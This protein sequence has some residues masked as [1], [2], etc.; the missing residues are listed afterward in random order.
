MSFA[1]EPMAKGWVLAG[2][3]GILL[4]KGA[5]EGILDRYSSG[6]VGK[7]GVLGGRLWR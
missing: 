1:L 4:G 5:R 6:A 3:V 7:R 2:K